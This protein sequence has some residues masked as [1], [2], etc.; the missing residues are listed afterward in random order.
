[1]ETPIEISTKGIANSPESESLLCHIQGVMKV[2]FCNQGALVQFLDQ[3][4]Q[5]Q[6]IARKPHH[7]LILPTHHVCTINSI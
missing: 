1:M 3:V 5:C 6:I 4:V 2:K 7:G